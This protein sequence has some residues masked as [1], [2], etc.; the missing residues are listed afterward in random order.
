MTFNFLV[1]LNPPKTTKEAKTAEEKEE[2]VEKTKLQKE[3]SLKCQRPKSKYRTTGNF[4]NVSIFSYFW[5]ITFTSRNIKY[6][7]IISGIISIRNLLHRKAWLTNLKSYLFSPFPQILK[8]LYTVLAKKN[9][10][11]DFL[12]KKLYL[13]ELVKNWKLYILK[14]CLDNL[15]WSLLLTFHSC[16]HFKLTECSFYRKLVFNIN[17]LLLIRRFVDVTVVVHLQL[18]NKE[19]S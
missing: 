18:W 1:W 13:W 16:I 5:A 4:Y 9:N 15:I 2:T 8:P 7:V 17:K 11:T 19:T 3:V 14:V 12:K 6:A 10:G